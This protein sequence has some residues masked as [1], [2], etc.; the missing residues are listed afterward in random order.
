MDDVLKWLMNYCYDH[1]IGVIYDNNLPA[2]APSDSFSN[3]RLVIFNDNYKNENEKPFMLAHEIGHIIDGNAEYYHLAYL[4]MERGE[5]SANRFAINLLSQYCLDNDI[6]F[7][8]IYQFAKA[9]GIPKDKYYL[10]E[11]FA[12][13]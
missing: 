10:L 4:G 2:D 13:E 12:E 11:Q 6:W 5:Y 8:T 9:F 7:E 1:G 3:P